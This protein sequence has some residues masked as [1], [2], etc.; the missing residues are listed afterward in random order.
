MTN[1]KSFI[2]LSLSVLLCSVLGT[3]LIFSDI[4]SEN[5]SGQAY[6]TDD[7][8]L[9]GLSNEMEVEEYGTDPFSDDS[10]GDGAKD[11]FEVY[12]RNTDPLN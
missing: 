9:D 10:D 3:V 8:D 6:A 12:I 1:L 4:P 11:G 7:D 5:L 2:F